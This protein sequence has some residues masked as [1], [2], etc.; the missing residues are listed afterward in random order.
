M[1]NSKNKRIQYLKQQKYLS[2]K[3]KKELILAGE[4][5]PICIGSSKSDI[6]GPV[7]YYSHHVKK[8]IRL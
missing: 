7:K 4:D 3:E 8:K 5:V 6:G 2:I 1:L